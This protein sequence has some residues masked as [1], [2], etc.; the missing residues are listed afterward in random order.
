MSIPTYCL[1]GEVLMDPESKCPS[2]G[3]DDG[4]GSAVPPEP[5]DKQ[6]TT[7]A[8]RKTVERMER[9]A[10]THQD[11]GEDD[12]ASHL[13]HWAKELWRCFPNSDINW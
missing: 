6:T 3:K 7:D 2:C 9:N 12:V 13:N 5:E 11:M 4:F 1:C 10:K 8:I